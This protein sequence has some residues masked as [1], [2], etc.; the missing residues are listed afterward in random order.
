MGV[1]RVGR[2]G[3]VLCVLSNLA[4]IKRLA[5]G[6]PWIDVLGLLSVLALLCVVVSTKY[7]SRADLPLFLGDYLKLPRTG[8]GGIA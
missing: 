6:E 4:W 8:R 1:L 5:A 7:K 2:I 3:W